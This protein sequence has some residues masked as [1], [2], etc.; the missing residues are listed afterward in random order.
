MARADLVGAVEVIYRVEEADERAWLRAVVERAMELVG[1][2]HRGAYGLEYDA[3]DVSQIRF[4]NMVMCGIEDPALARVLEVDCPKVY[5]GHPE[6]VES[7][8]R[9]TGHAPSR[10]L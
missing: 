10:R 4:S 8:F 7:I 2:A 9:R 3:S 1:R 6:L 5:Q